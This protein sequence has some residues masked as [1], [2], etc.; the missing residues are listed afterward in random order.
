M[1]SDMENKVVKPT[2]RPPGFL[3]L[4]RRPQLPGTSCGH[5]LSE[6]AAGA[7]KE[8]ENARKKSMTDPQ[9]VCPNCRTEI[10]L[11]E[12]LAEPLVAETRRRFE[13]QL[14]ARE[15]EFSRREAKLKQA[16]HELAKARETVDEQVAAKLLAERARIAETE[17]KRARTAIAAELGERDRQLSDLQQ[18]FA[19]RGEKLAEA[20]KAQ[21]D[22]LR[23]ERELDDARRELELTVEKQV[24][25]AL[26]TV[27]NKARVEAED[28]LKAKLS[29]KETQIAGMQRQIEDLRRKAEQGSQQLQGEAQEIEL[30]SLLR[31]R[32]PRDLIEPVA[33]GEFGGD[34]LHR[35]LGPAGQT[36]GTILWESK[37]T[38]NWSDNWLAKLRDDQRSAKADVALI[39]SSA[40]PRNVETFDLVDNVW[41]ADPRFAVPLAIALRQSLVDLAASRLAQD[42]QQSKMELV[43]AYL[44]GPRFRH[45]VEAI[46]EKFTYMQA[47]LDRERKT[48]MRLWSKREEQLRRVLESTAGLYGDLQGIA[49]R[50]MPEID[51][52]DLLLI[53]G[54]T[55]AAE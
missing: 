14:A 10:K 51:S 22:I 6:A 18:L 48:M 13:Q 45:R 25:E 17:T 24:Q 46:M 49:G 36:C 53:E 44:T 9:I 4:P 33:K 47:D 30:E 31:A 19:E 37:R 1:T 21:A 8:T 38:K 3:P 20:Q 7:T 5:L 27:R 15:V 26:V 42:G 40:L 41:V 32:F 43:Y 52:L 12:S 35:V 11:T 2:A 54:K 28:A 55:E 34:V 23:K 29:E 16:Q 50:A 39:V